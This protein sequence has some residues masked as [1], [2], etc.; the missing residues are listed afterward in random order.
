LIFADPEKPTLDKFYDQIAWFTI[1]SGAIAL[2]IDYQVSGGF[3]FLPHAYTGTGLTKNSISHRISD[4]YL[5]R[6]KGTLL[7]Y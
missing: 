3:D 5:V 2:S 6:K 1:K 7:G 4:H